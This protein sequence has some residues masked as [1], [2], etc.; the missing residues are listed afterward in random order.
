MTVRLAHLQGYRYPD[1]AWLR[2]RELELL[3]PLDDTEA[4]AVDD[5]DAA[6]SL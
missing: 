2:M 4:A 3:L 6:F 5:A 1:L